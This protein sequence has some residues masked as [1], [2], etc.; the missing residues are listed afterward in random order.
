[1]SDDQSPYK[2]AVQG[3]ILE[4]DIEA[5][6]LLLGQEQAHRFPEYHTSAQVDSIRNFATSYGDNNPLHTDEDYGTGT[7][8][9]GQIA[10]AI[11]AAVINKP[12]LGDRLPEELRKKTK[13][14]FKGLHTFVSGSNWTWY[15]PIRPGDEIYS[16]VG[17]EA[18]EVKDSEFAGTTLVRT[19]RDVK[20]NQNA[21]VIA[22]YRTIYI[23]A[24]RKASKKKK[25]YVHEPAI[26]TPEQIA[27]IDAA[28]AKEARRGADPRYWEDVSV[29][30]DIYP[31]QKGPLTATEVMVF[32]AGGYAWNPQFGR[33]AASR[34]AS[35][36]RGKGP[37]GYVPNRAGVPDTAYRVH[38][39]DDWAKAIGVPAA[40]DYG[41]MRECWMHHCVSDWMGDA[42]IIIHQ[43][44]TVRKFNYMGDLQIVSGKVTGKR[45][46]ETRRIV[47]VEIKCTNQRDEDTAFGTFHVV[48]P[49]KDHGAAAHPPVPFDLA[50]KAKAM[51]SRH[52]ELK[53]AKA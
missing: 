18:L 34:V 12:L 43:E 42:G 48:L 4:T 13:G 7:G 23:N 21:E 29:G 32:H 19:R 46:D 20:F 22:V 15:N 41:V 33:P 17:D 37:R 27:E 36:D 8:W 30:D 50:E 5:A 6:R 11:M 52:H 25:K 40:Y 24:E 14:L 9:G 49:S 35:L 26:W 51:L 31:I 38:W 45:Q 47:E 28:Y 1:M 53:A 16:F 39:D 3:E 10:P 2:E 44:D